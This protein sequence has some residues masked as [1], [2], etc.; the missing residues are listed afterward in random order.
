MNAMHEA[1]T[2]SSINP[3]HIHIELF[4]EL[5]PI[6]PGIVAPR[7]LCGHTRPMEQWIPDLDHL[8]A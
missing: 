8:L 1:L 4:G 7:K 6:N 3:T 2:A 5:P